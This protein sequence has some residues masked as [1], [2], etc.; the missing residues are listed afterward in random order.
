MENERRWP[1]RLY[2]QIDRPSG[3]SSIDI[4]KSK[5]Y[6]HHAISFISLNEQLRE[7]DNDFAD[8]LKWMCLFVSIHRILIYLHSNK[9][10]NFPVHKLPDINNYRQYNI[11]SQPEGS[12]HL[13]FGRLNKNQPLRTYELLDLPR[14][15]TTE[16]NFRFPSELGFL[17]FLR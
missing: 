10:T 14:E 3:L 11:Q 2:P 4:L 8:E 17:V 1:R 15:M 5:R 6:L 12:F 16:N 7:F 13:K 9:E